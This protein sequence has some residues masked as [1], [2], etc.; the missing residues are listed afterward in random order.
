[1]GAVPGEKLEIELPKVTGEVSV[2]VCLTCAVD[3]GIVVA[4]IDDRVLDVPLDLY[5][6]NVVTTG[7]LSWKDIDLSDGP[8][9]LAFEM[10]GS[11]PK[12]KPL[13]FFGIDYLRVRD[14]TGKFVLSNKSE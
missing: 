5:E 10:V 8:H 2:E 11:N 7:L 1:M 9:V 13:M 6:P 14:N 4:S 3:Y 12:G